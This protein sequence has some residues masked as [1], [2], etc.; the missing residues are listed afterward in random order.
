ML[1]PR[2]ASLGL[3]V[4][5][6][7][8]MTLS[9]Q[10]FPPNPDKWIVDQAAVIGLF[11]AL[12]GIFAGLGGIVASF[13]LELVRP[14]CFQTRNN[15]LG[16]LIAKYET[17][18]KSFCGVAGACG[19]M[20]FMALLCTGFSALIVFVIIPNW[21]AFAAHLPQML[22]S[23]GMLFGFLLLVGGTPVFALRFPWIGWPTLV[24]VYGGLIAYGFHTKGPPPMEGLIA[25]AVGYGGGGLLLA[26]GYGAYWLIK[27][28]PFYQTVCPTR[29]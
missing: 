15:Y 28:I 24:I 23:V 22:L 18:A 27:K 4:F 20:L 9:L 19:A 6:A 29:T 16:R 17:E 10:H 5:S 7:I 25:L 13:G 12:A 14:G 26:V 3:V 21:A 2:L 1:Y 8:V 11:L